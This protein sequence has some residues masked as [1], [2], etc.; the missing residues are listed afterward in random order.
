MFLT[1]KIIVKASGPPQLR[2]LFFYSSCVRWKSPLTKRKTLA[3]C[4]FELGVCTI[5]AERGKGYGWKS[6]SVRI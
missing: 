5:V 6:D 3:G 4:P 1:M 2:E